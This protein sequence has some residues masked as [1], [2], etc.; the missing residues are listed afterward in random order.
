MTAL[1]SNADLLISIHSNSI[2]NTSIRKI[3]K[4]QAPITGISV[5]ASLADDLR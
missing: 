3:S 2:G 1:N 5:P 4:A